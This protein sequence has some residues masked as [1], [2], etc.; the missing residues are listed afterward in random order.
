MKEQA[1]LATG[2]SR[3][4]H[5]APNANRDERLAFRVRMKAAK[6]VFVPAALEYTLRGHNIRQTAFF[7]GYARLILNRNAWQPNPDWE[8]GPPRDAASSE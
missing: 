4:A 3:E 7:G 6:T 1:D 8:S 2:V 5:E